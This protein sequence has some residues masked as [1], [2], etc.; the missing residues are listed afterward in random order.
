MSAATWTRVRHPE[1]WVV[2][3]VVAGLLS[4]ALLI[5]LAERGEPRWHLPIG[6]VLTST[7]AWRRFAPAAAVVVGLAAATIVR[8]PSGLAQSVVF[9]VVV[10]LVYYALGRDARGRWQ[11]ALELA[12]VGA[13]LPVISLTPGN[14][15]VVD[16]GSVWLFFFVMPWLTG[17]T[18]SAREQANVELAREARELEEDVE[19]QARRAIASER[20]RI[21]RDLHDVIAHNVSVMAIQVVAAR[22]V[23]ATDPGAASS[24]LQAVAACGREALVELRRMVGILNR[25]GLELDADGV[26]GLGQLEVLVDRA[27]LAGVSVDVD[28]HGRRRELPAGRDLVA[29]RVVQEALTNIIKHAPGARARVVV[30]YGSE[31]VELV[32]SNDA[33]RRPS[34]VAD[35]AQADPTYAEGH[36]GGRRLIGMRERLAL[37]GGTVRTTE[38]LDGGFEVVATLPA[39]DFPIR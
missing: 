1:W 23:T 19:E 5:D 20:T 2:D 30:R 31:R 32:I 8:D 37:Y 18:M 14:S 39:L 11:L 9:P 28:V 4:L 38:G 21:A 33:P 34:A 3:A 25:T 24:A 29:F 6:L 27:R 16:A 7:V 15:R 12:L 35:G 17:R 36:S 22:R 26:P 13:A 10:V